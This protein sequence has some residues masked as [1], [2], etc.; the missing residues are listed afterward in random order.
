LLPFAWCVLALWGTGRRNIRQHRH[1]RAH[2]LHPA[3]GMLPSVRSILT[4]GGVSGLS[5][6]R[7]GQIQDGDTYCVLL[8]YSLR[9]LVSSSQKHLLRTTVFSLFLVLMLVLSG[10]ETT[11]LRFCRGITPATRCLWSVGNMHSLTLYY[12]SKA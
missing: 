6:T 10:D 8:H 1:R 7:D 11:G 2:P 12:C 9:C 5:P 3:V 4:Q